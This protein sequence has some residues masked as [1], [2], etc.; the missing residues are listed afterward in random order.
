M[1]VP[2]AHLVDC[3]PHVQDDFLVALPWSHSSGS[4]ILQFSAACYFYARSLLAIEPDLVFGLVD[5]SWGGTAIEPWMDT[6]SYR[7]CKGKNAK[8]SHARPQANADPGLPMMRAL[9]G[10]SALGDV[11]SLPSTLFN[12]MIAPLVQSSVS[13]ILWYQGESNAADPLGYEK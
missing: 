7:T 13:A 12:S 9:K 4:N 6:V 1:Y 2:T 8:F 10:A 11:P 5:S 3:D